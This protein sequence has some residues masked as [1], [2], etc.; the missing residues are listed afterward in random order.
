[1]YVFCWVEGLWAAYAAASRLMVELVE[2]RCGW[3]LFAFSEV[4]GGI[5]E[6]GILEAGAVVSTSA[7]PP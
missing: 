3:L 7:S 6:A 1:M 5:C 4:K 2:A